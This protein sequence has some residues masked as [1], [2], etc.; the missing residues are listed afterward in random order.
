VLTAIEAWAA[1]RG[2]RTLALQ[3]VAANA[4]AVA[5]YRGVGFEPVATNRFWVKD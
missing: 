1:A 2:A 3:A 4:A 5:L